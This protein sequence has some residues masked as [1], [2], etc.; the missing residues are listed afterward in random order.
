MNSI[1]NLTRRDFLRASAATA[2]AAQLSLAAT[3]PSDSAPSNPYITCFYQFD[4]ACVEALGA[5][6]ALPNGPSFVH[7]FTGSYPGMSARPEQ[8]KLVHSAGKSFKFVPCL[9]VHKYKDWTKADD[10]QLRQWAKEFRDTHIPSGADAWGFNEMPTTGPTTPHLREVVARWIRFIHDPGDGAKF[11]C[12]F[13]FTERNT[14]P[15]KWEGDSDEFWPALDETCDVVVG[16]HYHSDGFIQ[17]N[18]GDKLTQHLFALPK[19][20]ITSGKKA[21]VNIA[22]K[23]YAVLHSSYYGPSV[24]GWAGLQ[25]NKA[26][27]G[28]LEGYY[29]RVI[30]ATRA[31]ELGKDRIGFGPLVT[32]G[33]DFRA[34]SSLAKALGNDSR[35]HQQT[36][37]DS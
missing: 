25:I 15:E 31:S 12:V 14:Q 28:E 13:Y 6:G 35:A 11:P 34:V 19:W 4:R 33:E 5:P 10:N 22:R 9:D 18:P 8:A 3:K 30:E 17:A 7:F 23:K 16:E 26:S 27:V 24:T 37:R 2:L 1:Q 36:S 20:L 32:K 21:Q 29:R